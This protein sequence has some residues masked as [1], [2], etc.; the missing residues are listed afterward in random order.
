MRGTSPSFQMGLL[1]IMIKGPWGRLTDAIKL[2]WQKELPF[3]VLLLPYQKNE[4]V[5]QPDFRFW[6]ARFV[7]NSARKAGWSFPIV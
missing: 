7:A 2:K 5:F 3:V 6:K 1:R 4:R